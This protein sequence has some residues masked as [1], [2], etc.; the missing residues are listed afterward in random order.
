MNPELQR[1]FI[2]N[3]IR[4]KKQDERLNFLLRQNSFTIVLVSS[5]YVHMDINQEAEIK[6]TSRD[7]C[8]ITRSCFH[9]AHLGND[10]SELWMLS[11]N[12]KNIYHKSLVQTAPPF[13]IFLV[14]L[15]YS[16]LR[17]SAQDFAIL[18]QWFK[19][20]AYRNQKPSIHPP[21]QKILTRE[22]QI[23]LRE[24]REIYFRYTP[25]MKTEYPYKYFLVFRFLQLV[26]T[27]FKTEHMVKFYASALYVS[28]DHLSKI[29]KE[30]THKSAKRCIEEKL[31]AKGMELLHHRI[32]IT[33]I[34]S[35]LG[36]KTSSHFGYVFKKHTSFTPSDYRRQGFFPS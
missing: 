3:H 8:L 29:V 26:E 33:E 23:L 10:T 24:L 18:L 21:G 25:E 17:L 27:Y 6:L 13:L 19:L 31:I 30:V 34:S 1:P 11:L 9:K 22:I 36:F 16:Q 7:V 12:L 35:L 14:S 32:S 20:L 5:G 4:K 15:G 28:A 2:V